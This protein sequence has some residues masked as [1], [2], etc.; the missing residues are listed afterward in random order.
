MA[1]LVLR[2]ERDLRRQGS[3]VEE[4]SVEWEE[5]RTEQL[6]ETEQA[7]ER[8]SLPEVADLVGMLG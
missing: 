7:E 1:V 2:W 8:Q 4:S 5:P 3:G 6:R